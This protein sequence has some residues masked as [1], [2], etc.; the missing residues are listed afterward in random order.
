MAYVRKTHDEWWLQTDYGYGDGFE[1]E[2]CGEDRR[3]AMRLLR[4][5][6]EN[7][8]QWPHRIKKHRV[9]NEA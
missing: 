1:D 4:E 8:P 5:Y 7:A 2:C 3:D 6:R 9:K